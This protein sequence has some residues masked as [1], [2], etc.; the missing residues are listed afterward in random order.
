MRRDNRRAIRGGSGGRDMGADKDVDKG[1][2]KGWDT[3]FVRVWWAGKDSDTFKC[4]DKNEDSFVIFE[5]IWLILRKVVTVAPCCF[6][7]ARK[8]RGREDM[9]SV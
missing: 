2:D 9:L 7:V 1:W 8:G 4:L 5:S 3:D 6:M